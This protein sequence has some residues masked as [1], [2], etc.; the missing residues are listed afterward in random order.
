MEFESD[1]AKADSNLQKHG[2][3]F[4]EAL[5][6]FADPLEVTIPDPDHSEGEFRFLSL[7]RSAAGRLLVVAYTEREG[8][9]PSCQCTGGYATGAQRI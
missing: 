9:Y 3:G 2:V 6:V 7:A 1:A 5:T 4:G 8:T